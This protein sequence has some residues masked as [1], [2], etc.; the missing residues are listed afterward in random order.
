M[1][2]RHFY[3]KFSARIE[4]DSVEINEIIADQNQLL[5]EMKNFMITSL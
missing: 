1:E 3:S 5:E 2:S 4:T